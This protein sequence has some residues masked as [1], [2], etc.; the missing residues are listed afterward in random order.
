MEF[1]NFWEKKGKL[2]TENIKKFL[3]ILS[4]FAPFIT[5]ELW[6]KKLSGKKSIHIEKWPSVE[7]SEIKKKEYKIPVQIN[8]KLRGVLIISHDRL[9]KDFIVEKAL[10]TDTINKYIKGKEYEVIYI[11]EKIINF[12]VK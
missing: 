8:G 5:D 9:K 11:E 4:P 12:I 2:S 7:K 6:Q 10:K 1:V 3:I